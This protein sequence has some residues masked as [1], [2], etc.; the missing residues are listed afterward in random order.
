M[1]C[2]DDP[3][4]ALTTAYK[5]ENLLNWYEIVQNCAVWMTNRI[6]MKEKFLSSSIL[7]IGIYQG[8]SDPNTDRFCTK[9]LI[10]WL[11]SFKYE[12]NDYI[13]KIKL[14]WLAP[15]NEAQISKNYLHSLYYFLWSYN[16]KDIKWAKNIF[17]CLFKCLLNK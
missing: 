13:F 16:L 4:Y 14:I 9:H 5:G 6:N 15:S 8:I 12:K 17:F 7:M 2:E 3:V 11:T 10:D 1:S